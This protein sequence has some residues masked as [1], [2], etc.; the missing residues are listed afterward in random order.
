M[1]RS[2]L[3]DIMCILLLKELL[4]MQEEVKEI[5]LQH[6]KQCTIYQLHFKNQQH[7]N[8]EDLD[9]ATPNY[10]LI[11]YNKNQRK[12]MGSLQ[13]YY[14]DELTDDTS[15]I[16]FP[17]KRVIN[18][19][20]FK[21]KTSIKGKTYNVDAVNNPAYDTNKSGLKLLFH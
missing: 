21:Y 20:S 4:L 16:N 9:V 6:L 19:E 18:S 5:G 15:D 2:Y 8:A 17:N 13:N 3:C 12:T 14:R 10:N 1:L 11:E 7:D